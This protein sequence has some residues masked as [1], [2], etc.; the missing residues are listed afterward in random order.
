MG[1]L[2]RR[3]SPNNVSYYALITT[4]NYKLLT[5]NTFFLFFFRISPKKAEKLTSFKLFISFRAYIM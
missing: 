2:I 1:S 3:V 4:Y 5:Q